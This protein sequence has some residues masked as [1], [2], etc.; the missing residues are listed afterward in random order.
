[1]APD[2]PSISR[3]QKELYEWYK[4]NHRPL[5]WRE[6][7]DP[8]RIWIS[9]VMLQQTTVQ[10][11]VP[12]YQR[13]LNRFPDLES[14]AAAPV[15]HVLEMW[16]GLGYYSRAK[17]LHRSAQELVNRGGFPKTAIELVEMPGFGPY[18]SR[19]VASLAFGDRVGVLDGNVIRV[20]CRV[21][22]MDDPW[23]KTVVRNKLQNFADQIGNHKQTHLINQ[24]MMELGAIICTPT[25]PSCVI[26]PIRNECTAYQKGVPT[27]YPIKRA[28]AAGKTILWTMDIYKKDGHLWMGQSKYTPF[29]K[30][31]WLPPGKIEE[32]N[33]K[34][35]K[36]HLRHGIT[37]Y[38]IYVK[39]RVMEKVPTKVELHQW[40]PIKELSRW[41]PSSVLRKVLQTIE[42]I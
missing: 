11:V 13:F 40:V 1:M 7:R 38:D 21:L 23:W 41:N 39:L 24:A 2:S 12:Y 28:K 36:F 22:S 9:E 32:V 27:A 20:L 19:A 33:D 10:V 35:K 5:P 16:A 17:L 3:I 18:T 42:K 25:N 8:Y 37:K 14:L 31:S 29:L 15:E 4:Q 26:C 30:G 6:S 34:P